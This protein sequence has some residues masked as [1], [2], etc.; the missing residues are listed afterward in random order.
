MRFSTLPALVALFATCGCDNIE[1]VDQ[2]SL[3]LTTG[4]SLAETT[5]QNPTIS[6]FPDLP[7]LTTFDLSEHEGFVRRGYRAEDVD[8]V[9][10]E[11]ATVTVTA[12]AGQDLGFL[13]ELRLYVEAPE[14]PRRLM[15]R[16]IEPTGRSVELEL[17]EDDLKAWLVG[18]PGHITAEG[19]RS[20]RPEQ[21]T[22][23]EVRVQ[24]EV[25]VKVL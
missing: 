12:P 8:F 1:K 19:V 15:A 22:S 16:A 17:T 13:G 18:T 23:L 3:G 7:G 20:Q 5:P 14:Q 6:T 2:F 21:R 4:V 9:A 10:L 25:S 24:F 11:S